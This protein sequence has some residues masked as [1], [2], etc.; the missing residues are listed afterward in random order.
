MR[1]TGN[2]ERSSVGNKCLLLLRR[3]QSPARF[4]LP[5]IAALAVMLWMPPVWAQLSGGS[6]LPIIV[7]NTG[8][9]AIR[10]EPKIMADM[11]I[12]DNGPG[13]RNYPTGP[14]NDYSGKIGI[15][16]RGSSSQSFPKKNYGIEIWD[17]AGNDTTAS[18]LGMPVE[19]DWV[20]H[21]PYSDKSLIRNML[22]M[23]IGRDQE[24]YASRTRLAELIINGQYQGV[25]VAMEK[26]KRDKNRVDI[27]KLEPHE[28]SGD[29]LTGGYIIKLDKFDGSNSGGGWASPYRP[30][31]YQRSD[32]Q[33]FFQYEYPKGRDITSQQA[34]YIRS[35]VTEFED[36]V[37]GPDFDKMRGGWRDYLDEASAIDF[38]IVN[39]LTRN[40]DG[41]RLSTFLYKD[42]DS[43][44]GKLYFGP[45]WDFNLAFG[46]A[47]YCQGG[48]HTGWALDF[49]SHCSGD[50]WL[51]P[52][53][54]KRF[55]QD[56][57]FIA[58]LKARWS[59]LR[60]GPYSNASLNQ[61]IDSLANVLQEPQARNFD[62]WRVLDRYVWPN[63][64][65]G[66]T[67]ANEINYLKTWVTNR[68]QW[69]DTGIA[70]LQG[71]TGTGDDQADGGPRLYPNPFD[72]RLHLLLPQ[73][74]A[75]QYRLLLSDLMGKELGF[76]D[77]LTSRE[78]P[79][80]LS[81]GRE[82]LA[83][84][85]LPGGLYLLQVLH[86]GRPLSTYKVLKQ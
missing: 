4:R 60:S 8:G 75:G 38:L 19:G 48:L 22:A 44:D 32:Q 50:F 35:Y 74:Q 67:Y 49:N 57:M 24:R 53:W 47:D 85:S 14:F 17:A 21:G 1:S 2:N 3:L 12:V 6:N 34:A 28:N 33:I 84:G 79:I 40:V 76:S 62:M 59:E 36:A 7:I 70:N 71:V 42:K 78:G 80:T 77:A 56:D 15:E 37:Y 23:R 30:P 58:N 73:A 64:Y 18:I 29:D 25:Y 31:Q 66:N 63:N 72:E 5:G 45:I 13:N 20:L 16:F 10:N 51:I 26:I 65:V 9:Q 69:L 54:W 52:F 86:D 68:L 55:L 83:G 11:Q 27:A 41:Y 39:E 61:Y 46:N 81:I 43:K 82:D